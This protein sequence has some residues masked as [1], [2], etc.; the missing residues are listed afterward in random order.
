MT[1]EEQQIRQE[2]R[3]R[4]PKGSLMRGGP[5]Q[6]SPEDVVVEMVLEER[7]VSKSTLET[8]IAGCNAEKA[9]LLNKIGTTY[10]AAYW[11]GY[12]DGFDA[13]A[14]AYGG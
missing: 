6:R 12:D 5:T 13:G 10:E 1:E 3:R 9:A 11:K 14:E 7:A 8:Y 2:Y 4:R